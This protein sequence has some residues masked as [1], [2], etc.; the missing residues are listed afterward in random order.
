MFLF[1]P[2]LTLSRSVP[3][4]NG[5]VFLVFAEQPPLRTA[6]REPA[7]RVESVYKADHSATYIAQWC[8]GGAS[9]PGNREL[10]TGME[11]LTVAVGAMLCAHISCMG[12]AEHRLK[13]C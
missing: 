8:I 9:V 6:F 11:T 4:V 7:A 1:A 12:S 13:L 5:V 10:Y 3:D 2:F